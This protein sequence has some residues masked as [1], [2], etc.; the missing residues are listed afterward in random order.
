MLLA[1]GNTPFH[2]DPAVLNWIALALT[3]GPAAAASFLWLWV[4][5]SDRG[6]TAR[7]PP[8]HE[9]RVEENDV[10]KA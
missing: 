9:K 10:P 5:H 2:D 6:A 8:I 3:L 1:H 4:T 7:K